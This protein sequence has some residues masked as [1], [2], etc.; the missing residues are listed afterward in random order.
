MNVLHDED[1]TAAALLNRLMDLILVNLLFVVCCVPVVTIGAAATAMYDV[2]MRLA[3]REEPDI[4]RA[5]FH[6]F[7]QNLKRAVVLFLGA[8]SA[9]AFLAVDFWCAARWDSPLRFISQVVI[10]SASY[11]YIALVS[12]VFPVL[13]WFGEP[14]SQ[15]VRH[16]FFLAMRNG[17]YTVFV[18]V[19][20]LLPF[21]MF[22]LMPWIFWRFLFLWLTA[23][24]AVLAYL[25]ALHLV[26]LF[27][28]ERVRAAEE[29]RRQAAERKRH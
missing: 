25:N 9:G 4:I 28:P 12:H 18:M 5:F 20:D 7:R 3:L 14:V 27:D 23:G 16:A 10:L 2:C 22:F 29:E 1:N 15:T 24:F 13:A 6:C 17:I 21:L 11:F 26:R 19:M 8:V